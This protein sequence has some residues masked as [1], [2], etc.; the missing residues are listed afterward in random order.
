M[1][2]A[3]D[4]NEKN[5]EIPWPTAQIASLEGETVVRGVALCK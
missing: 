2:P 3:A 5:A 4:W 1:L